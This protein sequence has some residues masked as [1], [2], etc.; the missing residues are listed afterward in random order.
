M[1]IIYFITTHL[2]HLHFRL[3]AEYVGFK[4]NLQQVD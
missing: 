1:N 2:F 4:H 3:P